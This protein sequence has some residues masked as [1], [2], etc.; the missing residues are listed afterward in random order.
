[1][2]ED[3]TVEYHDKVRAI[4]GSDLPDIEK[5]KRGFDMVTGGMVE[6]AHH[7]IE[8]AR[9]V[10]DRESR[11]KVQ[12]KMETMKAARRIFDRWYTMITGRRAWD[13]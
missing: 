9:S 7:E 5:L 11:V 8:L 13:E 1:M 12:I 6:H 4:V 2:E 3:A 10:D